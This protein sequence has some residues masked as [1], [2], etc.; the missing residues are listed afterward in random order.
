MGS[1]LSGVTGGSE[2]GVGDPGTDLVDLG[3]GP[4]RDREDPQ[5]AGRAGDEGRHQGRR[6]VGQ[7]GDQREVVLAD[8]EVVLDE[9]ATE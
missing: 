6:V 4:E 7:F 1:V 2:R 9:P 5:R 3:R 8:G